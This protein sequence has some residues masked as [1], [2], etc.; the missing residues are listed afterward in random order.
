MGISTGNIRSS[1]LQKPK[2]GELRG[3]CLRIGERRRE[4][5]SILETNFWKQDSPALKTILS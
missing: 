4:R 3:S 5:G 1:N 2:A